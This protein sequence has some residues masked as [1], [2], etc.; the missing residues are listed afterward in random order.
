MYKFVC[1]AFV[2]FNVG[3]A[4]NAVGTL[5]QNTNEPISWFM[6][7]LALFVTGIPAIF[8]CLAGR[9]DANRHTPNPTQITP[10]STTFQ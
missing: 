7:V 10:V 3:F 4:A 1:I 9:N 6:P 8:G 2:F 5:P